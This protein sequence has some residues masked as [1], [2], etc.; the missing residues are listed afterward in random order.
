MWVPSSMPPHGHHLSLQ[1]QPSHPCPGSRKEGGARQSVSQLSVAVKQLTLQLLLHLGG[2]SH[3]RER[4]TGRVLV[5]T[6]WPPVTQVLL[7]GK[8][9][10]YLVVPRTTGLCRSLPLS[11]L[12]FVSIHDFYKIL[13]GLGAARPG[14]AYQEPDIP[15]QVALE[16]RVCSSHKAGGACVC[17]SWDP[18][19][20]PR[21]QNRSPSGCGGGSEQQR[22][23]SCSSFPSFS[24]LLPL[25]MS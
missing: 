9:R 7:L 15:W 18:G 11:G 5:G 2:H 13:P 12:T 21:S 19:M 3:V 8:D 14:V 22:A 6:S 17:C 10:P 25:L 23:G 16:E 24:P 4:D 1:L 20:C